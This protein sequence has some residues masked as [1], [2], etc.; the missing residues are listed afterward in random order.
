MGIRASRSLT[1]IQSLLE[2]VSHNTLIFQVVCW[3]CIIAIYLLETISSLDSCC[4]YVS[5][6][7]IKTIEQ[8]VAVLSRFKYNIVMRKN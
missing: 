3:V 5:N 4:G 6:A 7:R 8:S 2:F 1:D